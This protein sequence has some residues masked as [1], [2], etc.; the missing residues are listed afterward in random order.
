MHRILFKWTRRVVYFVS[1]YE[2]FYCGVDLNFHV[3]C[4]G[5]LNHD[6]CGRRVALPDIA[7]KP[8]A[9]PEFCVKLFHYALPSLDYAKHAIV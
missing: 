7:G 5:I 1:G 6:F 4:G 3:L 8:S 9:V 2:L